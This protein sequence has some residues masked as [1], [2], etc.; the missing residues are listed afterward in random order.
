MGPGSRRD[1]LDDHF[2]DWNWKKLV[3]LGATLLCKMKE[4]NKKHT[5]HASAF[6]ELNKALKPET[7]AGWRAYVEYWEEN[8]NDA[9]VP[10]PFETKVSTITQAAV[11]LKLV[12]MESRQLCEGNDMSLHPDVSTSVFI[13]TGIDLESEHLR[14]C[15][16]SDFSLQGAHQ[17]DRQKTVLMQQWNALQCKVDAWKRMQLLYTPTVQLLSSRMEPIGMP[18]NPEDIKLFLPSSL[19]ADSVSCSPHLFTIEWELRIAQAGDALDDIRRSLRLRDYM[20][21]FKWNWIHGQSA[22][23]CVQNALGRVEARAA[24]A[25]NKYCAA[26]AAL[27]SLAPVLNKKGES[28]G[29]RQLLWIWMV[30][31][32][33]DDEDEVVQD[34]LRIEWC[35][36]HARM[37]RWKEEIELLREEMR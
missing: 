13:A 37:M 24:A 32:V 21:T 31:G 18:D 2:G 28:E 7:T 9:S 6:E 26:H 36:A 27:S 12:E 23:T 35:K 15:F 8:P 4:A 5:A 19:T 11:R 3:G 22:N 14:H 1:T 25:A 30:E 17:T 29:R 16:Q 33:G 34:C 10:N 20:Y